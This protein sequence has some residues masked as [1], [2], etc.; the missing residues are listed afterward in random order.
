M[1]ISC[2]VDWDECDIYDVI[3]RNTRINCNSVNYEERELGTY[4]KR[5]REEKELSN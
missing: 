2:A 5:G 4:F 1:S 3:K